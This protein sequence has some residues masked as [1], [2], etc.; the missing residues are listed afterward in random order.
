[1]EYFRKKGSA[2]YKGLQD[3]IKELP[4]IETMVEIGSAFGESAEIF[5]QSD[6]I[7]KIICIDPW[8]NEREAH[9]DEVCARNPKIEKRKGWGNDE[10]LNF[11]DK[12][13]D[14]VYIDGHHSYASAKNDIQK[15]LPK[16]KKAI[17]GHDYCFRFA[18]IPLAVAEEITGVN[19]DCGSTNIPM[20]FE[21]H[22][23]LVIL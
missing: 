9:F 16:C 13:I 2:Q 11:K 14:L 15:W 5:A 19:A 20:V 23:W 21:D 6:K 18:G 17:G 1:M 4:E 10:V 12:S 3:F 7:K 22:S 8:N